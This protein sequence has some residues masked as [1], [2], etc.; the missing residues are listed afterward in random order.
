MLFYGSPEELLHVPNHLMGH[1]APLPISSTQTLPLCKFLH[2]IHLELTCY[3][4]YSFNHVEH[5][6]R[7]TK[8]LCLLWHHQHIE[9]MQWIA[10]IQGTIVE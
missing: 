8:L 10:S 7:A 9:L 2:C 5:L 6:T 3:I 4:S 1:R